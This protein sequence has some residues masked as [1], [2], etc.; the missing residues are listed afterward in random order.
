MPEALGHEKL[1]LPQQSGTHSPRDLGQLVGTLPN[2]LV[3]QGAGATPLLDCPA[4]VISQHT[5]TPHAVVLPT[6]TTTKA[7]LSC[8]CAFGQEMNAARIPKEEQALLTMVHLPAIGINLL[9]E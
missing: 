7:H 1:V 2:L 6:Q 4:G 3:I 5:H 9:W 8:V